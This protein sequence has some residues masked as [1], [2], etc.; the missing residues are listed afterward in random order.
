MRV[1]VPLM[2]LL[3]PVSGGINALQPGHPGGSLLAEPEPKQNDS[4][5]KP[6]KPA[7]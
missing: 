5:L 6:A 3:W 7:M 4:I 2:F 1:N